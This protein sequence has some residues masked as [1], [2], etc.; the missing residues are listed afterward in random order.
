MHTNTGATRSTPLPP[1]AVDQGAAIAQEHGWVFEVYS[2][3]DY[4]VD[5]A[6]PVGVAHAG[7]LG[8]PFLRRGHGDLAGTPLRMQYIVTDADV[9]QAC[10]LV[11][12]GCVASS[13]TSPIIPGYHFVSITD[14]AVSKASGVIALADILGISLDQV[15]MVGD[16]QNDVSALGVA[17]HPVAMGNGHADAK[18]VAKYIVADVEN[19]GVAEALDLA[20][21]MS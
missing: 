21:S 8:M 10:L 5:D 18:A 17:G 11:P 1:L 2:D 15:M 19:D 16:G 20:R 7:L 14:A 9:D 3:T 6:A 12:K 13:A 4:V